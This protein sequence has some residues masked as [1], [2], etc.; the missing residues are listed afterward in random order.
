M[1]LILSLFGHENVQ[2][3]KLPSTKNMNGDHSVKLTKNFQCKLF[4]MNTSEGE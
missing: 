4:C 3:L 1:K 2:T